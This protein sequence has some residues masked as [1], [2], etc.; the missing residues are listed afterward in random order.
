M[1]QRLRESRVTRVQRVFGPSLRRP[2]SLGLWLAQPGLQLLHHAR[3]SEAEPVEGIDPWKLWEL[4][5]RVPQPPRRPQ[6][7]APV[8]THGPALFSWLALE[9]L[10]A[11]WHLALEF[12][13]AEEGTAQRA[14]APPGVGGWEGHTAAAAAQEQRFDGKRALSASV[15][16]F[17]RGAHDSEGQRHPGGTQGAGPAG[18]GTQRSVVN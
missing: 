17:V 9:S 3:M 11:L 12:P 7:S 15:R 1:F 5:P 8:P 16:S 18:Q 6:H 10:R 13:L 4:D 2:L 14:G